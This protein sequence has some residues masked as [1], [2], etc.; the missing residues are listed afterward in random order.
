MSADDDD[1]DDDDDVAKAPEDDEE[2][3]CEGTEA[4]SSSRSA[5]LRP[6]MSCHSNEKPKAIIHLVMAFSDAADIMTARLPDAG[7][8]LMQNRLPE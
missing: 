1:D 7:V 4:S 3:D 5:L 2:N 6:S 8:S